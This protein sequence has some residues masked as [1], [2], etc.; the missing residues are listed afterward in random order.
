MYHVRLR[1]AT[2]ENKGANEKDFRKAK[3]A[4]YGPGDLISAVAAQQDCLEKSD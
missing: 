3:L 1:K 2:A 4:V